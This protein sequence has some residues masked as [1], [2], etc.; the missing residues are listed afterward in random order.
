MRNQK[1]L[2]W[3]GS[4]AEAG[5]HTSAGSQARQIWRLIYRHRLLICLIVGL[6]VVLAALSQFLARPLYVSTATVQV[7][8]T[9]DDEAEARNA[10]RVENEAKIYRSRAVAEKVV[11]DLNLTSNR[12]FMEL[13]GLP[14]GAPKRQVNTLAVTKLTD[15]VQIVNSEQSDLIDIK[16]TSPFP[17]LGAQIANQYPV[18]AQEMRMDRRQK[19]RESLLAG[20]DKESARLGN[21]VAQ[22]DERVADFR[23]ATRMLPGAG[24][25]EDLNQINRVAVEA[26][27]A[28]AMRSAMAARS[29]GVAQAAGARS[30][31][32]ADSPLLQQQ[33]REYDNLLNEKTRLETL[34]GARHPEIIAV[35]SQ[36]Q[37]LATNIQREQASARD[38]ALAEAN[39]AASQ[40]KLLAQSEASASAARANQLQAQMNK[41]VSKA[42][43]NNNNKAQLADL[44]RRAEVARDSY[45]KTRKTAE[46]V[47]ASLGLTSANSTV[48]SPGVVPSEPVY[49]TPA[50]TITGAALGALLLALI[51]VFVREFMDDR[52]RSPDQI[53]R[54]FGLPTFGMFPI[55]PNFRNTTV[56]ESPVLREPHSLFAEVARAV[57][58]EVHDLAAS[59][60]TQSVLI[61]S[62]LSGEG[63]STVAISLCAA[64]CAA[65][66]RAVVVDFDV[67]RPGI[68]Q[69]IQKQLGGP[70]LIDLLLEPAEITSLPP[71]DKNEHD[72][73]ITTY[74]P[75]AISVRGPV[76]NPASVFTQQQVDQLL[77]KLRREFDLIVINAPSALAVRDA[78]TFARIADHVIVVLRWGYSTTDQLSA[79]LTQLGGRTDGVVFDHVD[80]AEHARRG[81]GDSVQY[82]MQNA[83]NGSGKRSHR[84]VLARMTGLF[85]KI[86]KAWAK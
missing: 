69:D 23:R 46:E 13:V 43:S 6:T 33:K 15:F 78:R 56:E 38:I 8:L 64:A 53:L 51:F 10:K 19:R 24:S 65:G 57:H 44:E 11:E 45:M 73:E 32:G 54:W 16:I 36:L 72:R 22:A 82:Y 74:K 27:S 1:Q 2:L 86:E 20:L 63:K 39:A 30:I 81:Y 66:R 34:F 35:Q 31:A 18:A 28:D 9:D 71:P 68:L 79:T 76:R 4:E 12:P 3:E 50:R 55:V 17:K 29:A 62:P 5:A 83:A 52:L 58:S 61:T 26:A 59:A 48:V 41:M 80:Y 14:E 67:R 40:Q 21:E 84:G 42:F 47:R 70:D 85:R 75:V 77:T 37:A 49:P 25:D 7:E 60:E